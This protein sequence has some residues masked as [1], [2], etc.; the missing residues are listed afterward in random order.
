M[1]FDINNLDLLLAGGAVL[2][3]ATGAVLWIYF[4]VTKADF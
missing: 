2:T 3:Y 1:F 4:A